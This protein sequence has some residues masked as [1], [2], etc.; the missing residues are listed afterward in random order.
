LR[1][2]VCTVL[3]GLGSGCPH[4]W[5]REGTIERAA[6]RDWQEWMARG[7]CKLDGETWIRDCKNYKT[8][9]GEHTRCPQACRPPAGRFNDLDEDFL[10][11]D[12]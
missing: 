5:S 3:L 6:R 8:E 2:L 9:D 1:L 7:N 11:D 4:A 10:E 12:F